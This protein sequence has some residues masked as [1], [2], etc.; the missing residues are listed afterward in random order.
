MNEFI[1][2]FSSRGI[3]IHLYRQADTPVGKSRKPSRDEVQEVG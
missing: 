2:V 1:F 3:K